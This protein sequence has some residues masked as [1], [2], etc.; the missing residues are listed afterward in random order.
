MSGTGDSGVGGAVESYFLGSDSPP[1]STKSMDSISLSTVDT[2]HDNNNDNSNSSE[3]SIRT[4]YKKLEA[5][6]K[7]VCEQK[8]R[9]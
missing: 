3:E 8:V 7:T 2:N 5:K 1:P 9:N 6:Y 4:K